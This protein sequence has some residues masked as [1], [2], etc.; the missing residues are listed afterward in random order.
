MISTLYSYILQYIVYLYT[1]RRLLTAGGI[2]GNSNREQ[3]RYF[4]DK[5]IKTISRSIV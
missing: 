3:N 2:R 5:I 4:P 1:A